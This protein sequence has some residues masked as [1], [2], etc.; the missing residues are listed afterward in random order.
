MPCTATAAI[1]VTK[2]ARHTIAA[3]QKAEITTCTFVNAGMHT[4]RLPHSCASVGFVC[5]IHSSDNMV[6]TT[7]TSCSVVV[8]APA[9][10]G[11]S[12]DTRVTKA[13]A[14]TRAAERSGDRHMHVCV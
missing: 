13:P 9:M 6:G 3:E 7:L 4:S 5:A 11:H 12:S 10:H 2:R 14:H 8:I 1:R